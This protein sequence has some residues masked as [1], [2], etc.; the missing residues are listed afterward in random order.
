MPKT[1]LA[2]ALRTLSL[3]DDG[4]RLVEPIARKLSALP[5]SQVNTINKALDFGWLAWAMRGVRVPPGRTAEYIADLRRAAILCAK[6][7]E[8][9]R[10]FSVSAEGWDERELRTVFEQAERVSRGAANPGYYLRGSFWG[11]SNHSER[12]W[13]RSAWFAAERLVRLGLRAVGIASVQVNGGASRTFFERYFGTGGGMQYERVRKVLRKIQK[14]MWHSSVGIAYQGMGVPANEQYRETSGS[15][16]VPV[17]LKQNLDEWGWSREGRC[18]GFGVSFFLPDQ[19]VIERTT[20]HTVE[21]LNMEVSR[22]GAVLHELSHYYAKTADEIVPA[23]AFHHLGRAPEGNV[24]AYSPKV[25]WA[26]AQT[27]PD[28]AVN[29]ADSY[30]SFC[31]DAGTLW[32]I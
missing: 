23:A 18:I 15:L 31:E 25:C 28:Q 3:R 12:E 19:T 14:G 22:G 16:G 27:N 17:A 2:K 30:R 29:N 9:Q 32:V 20:P 10:P 24:Q 6:V 4:K 11:F 13:I 21:T 26:L 8:L 5:S 7:Y 1:Y